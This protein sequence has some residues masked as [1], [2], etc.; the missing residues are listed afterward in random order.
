MT[1][2][3][4]NNDLDSLAI[5]TDARQG[6]RMLARVHSSLG[7]LISYP[8]THAAR[9]ALPLDN[10]PHSGE[11]PER[12]RGRT[13]NQLAC[14]ALEQERVGNWNGVAPSAFVLANR[15]AALLFTRNEA[16]CGEYC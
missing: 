14:F 12:Q 13:G 6:E 9:E 3:L 10:Y 4:S 7:R 2:L 16:D 11:C 8:N 1:V 5:E 15:P